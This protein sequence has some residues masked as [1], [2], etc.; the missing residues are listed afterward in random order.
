MSVLRELKKRIPDLND[1]NFEKVFQVYVDGEVEHFSKAETVSEDEYKRYLSSNHFDGEWDW[2]ASTVFTGK[3]KVVVNPKRAGLAS[4]SYTPKIKAHE[5]I[6]F[7]WEETDELIESIYEAN[8]EFYGRGNLEFDKVRFVQV[9]DKNGCLVY[10]IDSEFYPSD[11]TLN[12]PD[13]DP[14]F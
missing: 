14:D 12:M 13:N 2:L 3:I 9:E 8:D 4:T 5:L 10:V 6:S 1:R 7:L 11:F